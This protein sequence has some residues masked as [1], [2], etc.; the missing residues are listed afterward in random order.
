MSLIAIVTICLHLFVGI[1]AS[2]F[3]TYSDSTCSA[4]NV[5]ENV[6]ANNA[7]PAGSCTKLESATTDSYTGFQFLTLDSGCMSKSPHIGHL[8]VAL[9][10]EMSP[11][12]I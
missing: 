7:Y 5:L 6:A 4:T 9:L 8:L 3:A 11:D 1:E 12:R 10:V 2:S